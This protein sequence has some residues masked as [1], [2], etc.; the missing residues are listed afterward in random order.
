MDNKKTYAVTGGAG[1][2]GSHIVRKLVAGGAAVRVID[3]LST[4]RLS[5]LTG[6]D[7]SA[8]DFIRGDICDLEFLREA[9]SGGLDG[10]FHLAAQPS[11]EA[12]TRAPLRA[13]QINLGGTLNVL[14]AS[15]QNGAGRVVLSSSCAVYGNEAAD[16]V[17]R[18]NMLPAPASPYAAQK[19]A[20]E[21]YARVYAE[22]F[23]LPTVCLRYFNVY[24]PYQDP[25]GDYAAVVPLF[26][27]AVLSG[28]TAVIYGD[29][30]QTRDFVYVKD[31]AA[32][33]IA[34]MET[35]NELYP[36]AVYNVGAG[37]SYSVR[38]LLDAV[39]GAIGVEAKVENAAPRAGEVR[40]S[41]ADTGLI[42]NELG[43]QPAY[44]LARGLSETVEFFR[45]GG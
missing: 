35:E 15:R 24:G 37:S 18:E 43:W 14:E 29:G 3:N 45:T 33:N 25:A 12:S 5:N 36:G 44:D 9:F 23:G 40:D 19:A 20:G 7:E 11:V 30:R 8:F 22:L 38:Q 27:Q 42:R 1:F 2:I 32:A 34:V 41:R 4:G 6:I 39:A 16:G 21:L 13:D 26:I 10:V 28:K 17:C 31:V